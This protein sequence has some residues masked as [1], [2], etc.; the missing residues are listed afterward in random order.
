MDESA[1]V[2]AAWLEDATEFKPDTDSRVLYSAPPNIDTYLRTGSDDAYHFL[3]GPKGVGKSMLIRQKAHLYLNRKSDS[4]FNAAGDELTETISFSQNIALRDIDKFRDLETWME[5]WSFCIY[6]CILKRREVPLPRGLAQLLGRVSRLSDLLAI[7]IRDRSN[8]NQYLNWIPQMRT[9]LEDDLQSGVL[10]CID[11]IDDGMVSL[12]RRVTVASYQDGKRPPAVAVWE[13]SQNGALVAAFNLNNH[14]SHLKILLTLRT[15]AFNN[16][17]HKSKQN[18]RAKSTFPAFDQAD[19]RKMFEKKVALMKDYWVRPQADGMLEKL[20]G[21]SHLHHP[22]GGTKLG[23]PAEEDVFY[24]IYRH[25][26]GRQRGLSRM[27]REITNLVRS[28]DYLRRDEAGRKHLLRYKIH[29]TSHTL[30]TSY[31]NEL[32]PEFDQQCLENFIRQTGRNCFTA[33]EAERL[34]QETLR[35]YYNIGL[36][37]VLKRDQRS[38]TDSWR[39]SFKSVGENGFVRQD[40]LPESQYYFTHPALDPTFY[41]LTDGEKYYNLYNVIGYERP[42]TIPPSN[43]VNYVDWK[44]ASVSGSRW[45]KKGDTHTHPLRDYYQ[46]LFNDEEFIQ[47]RRLERFD[48]HFQEAMG[49]VLH[50]IAGARSQHLSAEERERHARACRHELAEINFYRRHTQKLGSPRDP[51]LVTF[52]Y[53]LVGR[54]VVVTLFLYFDLPLHQIKSILREGRYDPDLD[55]L[56]PGSAPDYLRRAFFIAGLRSCGPDQLRERSNAR[57]RVWQGL[58]PQEQRLFTQ[59]RE[60]QLPRY[61]QSFTEVPD[62]DRAALLEQLRHIPREFC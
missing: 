40:S 20:V 22:Y 55:D 36:V 47:S 48:A 13:H 50:L 44:P 54:L 14:H 60:Q 35:Y 1:I 57:C 30:L 18:F 31:L 9:L 38:G 49:A 16:L 33:R 58:S 42:F 3:I 41:R 23:E 56:K 61:L 25:T 12:L 28:E 24:L 43:H 29:D 46:A 27:G 7:V 51:E 62:A 10:L 32:I 6:A 4:Y 11:N 26:F 15:E 8:L 59:F 21:F 45:I 17:S 34:D 39:Q 19:L 37:G 53:R 2:T 5:I 52:Y